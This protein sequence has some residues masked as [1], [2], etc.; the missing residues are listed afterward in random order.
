MYSAG[1]SFRLLK[2]W[3]FIFL[4]ATAVKQVVK[5]VPRCRYRIDQLAGL[6]RRSVLSAMTPAA[7][8]SDPPAQKNT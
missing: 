4:S 3:S 7:A 2:L 6:D 1:F 8:R 5:G